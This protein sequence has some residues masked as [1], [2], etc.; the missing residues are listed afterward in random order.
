MRNKLSNGIL[1][2]IFIVIGIGFLGNIFYDWNFSIFFDGWWTLFII[3]PCIYSM[4]RSGVNTGN[5]I[6][7][8]VGVL[9]L[10]NA[11]DFIESD[12]LRKAIWPVILIL[13]GLSIIFKGFSSHGF[14]NIKINNDGKLPDISAVFAGSKPNFDNLEFH[15]VNCSAI[16]GGVD[17]NLRRAIITEDCVINCNAIF[18]GIDIM[19]PDNV[20]VKVDALP[21][22]G[23]ADNKFMSS[24]DINAPTVYIN[25]T[26]AFGGLEIK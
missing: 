11:Q 16:F 22:L 12:N 19:L 14:K 15:G 25:A 20:K 2:L 10:I 24:P 13:I 21:I 26:C 17:L 1:G 3:I 18:G 9:L 8:A 6:G 4:V 23:G 7:L 5:L